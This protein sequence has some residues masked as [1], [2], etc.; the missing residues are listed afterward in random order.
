VSRVAVLCDPRPGDCGSKL[1]T[2]ATLAA[3]IAFAEVLPCRNPHC[4]GV[5]IVAWMEHGAVATDIFDHRR[6]CSLAE[7]LEQCYPRAPTPRTGPREPSPEWWPALCS[8]NEPLQ[9]KGVVQ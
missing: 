4:S 6:R 5:H 2:F 3:A 1:R 8:F 7:E 9:P